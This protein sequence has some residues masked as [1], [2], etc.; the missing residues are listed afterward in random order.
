VLP[1]AAEF[2]FAETLYCVTVLETQ[3]TAFVRLYAYDSLKDAAGGWVPLR[4][5]PVVNTP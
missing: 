1:I 4:A 3:Y 5:F 2:W